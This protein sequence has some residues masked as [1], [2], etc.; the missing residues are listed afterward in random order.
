MLLDRTAPSIADEE[1]DYRAR[2]YARLRTTGAVGELAHRADVWRLAHL[3]AAGDRAAVPAATW[4]SPCTLT[5]VLGRLSVNPAHALTECVGGAEGSTRRARGRPFARFDPAAYVPELTL[6]RGDAAASARIGTRGLREAG[7]RA[8]EACCTWPD[9][10]DR[11]EAISYVM[12]RLVAEGAAVPSLRGKK[13][14]SEDF[15]EDSM[16]GVLEY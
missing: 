7:F 14:Q 12:C 2:I 9:A 5:P 3:L 11:A 10:A 1:T 16:A 13:L 15:A 6:T 8:T 4:A